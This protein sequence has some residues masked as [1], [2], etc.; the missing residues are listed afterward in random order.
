M[1]IG[2]IGLGLLIAMALLSCGKAESDGGGRTEAGPGP[3]AAAKAA[4]TEDLPPPKCPTRSD[5]IMVTLDGEPGAQNVGILMA[6]KKDFFAKA[7][8]SVGV[9]GP[10]TPK[11]PV[12]YVATGVDGIG[13]T[14]QPQLVLAREEGLPLVAIGSLVPQATAALIWLKRSGIRGIADL[15]GKT[16]AIPGVPFQEELLE[17]ILAR[18]GLT[19]E[20]VEVRDSSYRTV[21][22]LLHGKADAIFGSWN[23]E[24]AAL[25]AQGAEPV[26]KRVQDLGVPG[27]EEAVVIA[28]EECVRKHPEVMRRFMAAVARGTEAA[29]QHRKEAA[30]RIAVYHDFD[31]QFTMNK[32]RRQ[33]EVTLP[34]LVANAQMDFGRAR[35]LTAWMH[36]EGMIE[37]EPPPSTLASNKFVARP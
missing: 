12:R 33:L 15:K 3:K 17:A 22:A 16:I 10:A 30:N 14:Q 7:G 35:V 18:A 28:R 1:K 31:P 8:L 32:L 13:V 2:G 20:D 37:R 27:Y 34:L 19:P 21:G 9:A 6:E 25:E 23:L 26:V 4:S 36:E 29:R 5:S 24:G 11:R